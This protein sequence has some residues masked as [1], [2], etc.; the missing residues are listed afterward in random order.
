MISLPRW[1]NIINVELRSCF[2]LFHLR[3]VCAT[4]EKSLST[5]EFHIS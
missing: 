3:A 2:P 1:L 5:S 4:L